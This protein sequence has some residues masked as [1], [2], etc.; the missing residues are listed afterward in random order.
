MKARL[1]FSAS[2]AV[3]VLCLALAGCGGGGGGD[4]DDGQEI[5]L[6]VED[7][8]G[9]EGDIP[10]DDARPDAPDAPEDATTEEEDAPPPETVYFYVDPDFEGSVKDGSDANPWNGLGNAEWEA[11]DA[12]LAANEVVVYFS[13]RDA[14][15][16]ADEASDREI[17]IYRTDVSSRRVTLDG[18]SRY[19]T[20]DAAPSWADYSGTSRHA[21]TADYPVNTS[22]DPVKRSYVTI[23]GF[24]IVAGSGG[25]GG[26]IIYYWGGDHVVIEDNDLSHHP[27]VAHGAAL[28][29]GYAHTQDGGGNGGCTDLVIRNNVIHDTAGECIYLGG[30]ED[31]GLP[32]HTGIL[33][34]GNTIYNCGVYGGQGDCIDVKDGH[35]DVVI[36]GN[37]CSDGQPSENVNGIPSHSAI[38]AEGNIIHDMPDNGLSMGTYWGTGFSGARIANNLI[39]GNGGDGIY[40]GTDDAARPIDDTLIVNNTIAG[41]GEGGILVGS[42]GTAVGAVGITNN[43]VA[44]NGTGLLGWGTPDAVLSANDVFGNATAYSGPFSDQTGLSG[45]IAQDPLFADDAGG[46]YHLE[47][48]SPCIDSGAE[49]DVDVD[50]E[51]T[52]R[53]QGSG[54][55][56]GAY[57]FTP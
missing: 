16:D 34:E 26:Q 39:Y 24:R 56:M 20:D 13:A 28:Q 50:L 21:V 42:T 43:I 5:D 51:G 33:V 40:I 46:D 14:G 22:E 45:N 8:G 47:A 57:E 54:W 31:T 27:D 29:F 48:G 55:D 12:A 9:E 18:M 36:R 3:L 4:R 44:L 25:V 6:I 1:S 30:S 35:T 52:S 32:A 23:R 38:V 41:N 37:V 10:G 15:A 2:L 11:V 53:P 49:V 17:G 19:N 7:Q